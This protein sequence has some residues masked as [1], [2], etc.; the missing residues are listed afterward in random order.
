MHM[1]VRNSG[2]DHVHQMGLCKT[3]ITYSNKQAIKQKID[4]K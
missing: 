3:R 2:A 1:S 4:P